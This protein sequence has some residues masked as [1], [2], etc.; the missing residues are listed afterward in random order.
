MRDEVPISF[1]FTREPLNLRAGA[2][3][4]QISLPD[5]LLE[6]ECADMGVHGRGT[7]FQE[8]EGRFRVANKNFPYRHSHSGG[9]VFWWTYVVELPPAVDFLFW[10]HGRRLFQVSEGEQRL[11]NL[12]R[13][14]RPWSR[15]RLPHG[16]VSDAEFLTRL[17]GKAVLA[18][19]R[20]A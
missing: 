12:W 9:N 20:A 4:V 15:G 11:F 13:N 17:I 14:G 8:R 16:L 2:R 19:S 5:H 1:C 6:L 7:A 18:E 3:C 10:L